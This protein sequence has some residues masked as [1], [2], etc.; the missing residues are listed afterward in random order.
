MDALRPL[1]S[2]YALMRYRLLIEIRW[3]R[4]CA[5]HKKLD[6]PQLSAKELAALEELHQKFDR[7]AYKR[8][9]D[10][11]KVCGHDV[12]A[13]ELYIGERLPEIIPATSDKSKSKLEGTRAWVHFACTSEDINNL[14]WALMLGAVRDE[15]LLPAYHALNDVLNALIDQTANMPMLSRTHGQPASPTTMGKELRVFAWRIGRQCRLLKEQTIFGKFNGAVGNYN[16]HHVAYP[17]LDWPAIS[18]EFVSS[19]GLEWTPISTQIETRDWMAE[20]FDTVSRLNTVLLDLCRDLWAY[21][22]LGY[23]RQ[24]TAGD[25]E[26][27]S[28]TMP[29]KINPIDFENAEGNIGIANSLLRHLSEKLPVSRWQRDLSDST[30]MRNIGV[31][32]GHGLLAVLSVTRGMP[33]LLADKELMEQE[34]TENWSVLAEAAQTIMRRH[35]VADAYN[36]LKKL[37]RGQ[38]IDADAMRDFIEAVELPEQSKEQLRKLKPVDYVGLAEE[39]SRQVYE[40]NN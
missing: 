27:G 3:L 1:L 16:A 38:Q 20:Y 23:F 7:H 40:Q 10:I 2:E 22:S 5:A 15:V 36:R 31:A 28:S 25:H 37:T 24:N 8:I 14:A 33:K 30:A 4:Y 32:L 19:L 11:E 21:V 17:E 18:K 34:L 29:H 39:L 12:K 6:A 26:V 13:V 9:K 35:G